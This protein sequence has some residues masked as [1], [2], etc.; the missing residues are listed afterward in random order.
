MQE[1]KCVV[2]L[3]VDTPSP[4]RGTTWDSDIR[5]AIARRLKTGDIIGENVHFQTAGVMNYRIHTARKR[6]KGKK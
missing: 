6:T 5:E 3:L 1:F 2:T 4:P